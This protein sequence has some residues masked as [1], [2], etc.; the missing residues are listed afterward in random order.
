[1]YWYLKYICIYICKHK[2][3]LSCW[4]VISF[5]TYFPFS[6]FIQH[7]D[8]VFFWD[9]FSWL[10]WCEI[11]TVLKRKFWL[12]H[13]TPFFKYRLKGLRQDLGILGKKSYYILLSATYDLENSWKIFNNVCKI[14]RAIK[15]KLHL[16][17]SSSIVRV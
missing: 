2:R 16:I 7:G 13:K 8:T 15:E 17:F 9:L 14:F 3:N 1:M 6:I 11:L 10:K 12:F 5:E 4:L